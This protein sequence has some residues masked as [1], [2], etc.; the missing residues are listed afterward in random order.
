MTYFYPERQLEAPELAAQLK[1]SAENRVAGM[2]SF[3]DDSLSKSDGD[4]LL[5]QQLSIADCFLFMLG[6]WTRGM[7]KPARAYPHLGPYMDRLFQR[8]AISRALHKEG[9]SAPYY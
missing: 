8:P 9:L 1:D 5:G 7:H 6:R 2:L 3:L 4:Y